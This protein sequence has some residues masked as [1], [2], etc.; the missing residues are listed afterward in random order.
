[1]SAR[2]APSGGPPEEQRRI[3]GSER[4]PPIDELET[5]ALDQLENPRAAEPCESQLEP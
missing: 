2:S 3:G 1:M 5:M 4:R